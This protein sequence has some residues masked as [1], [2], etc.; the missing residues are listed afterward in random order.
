MR[1]RLT[2]KQWLITTGALIAG[3]LVVCCGISA[4]LPSEEPRRNAPI[5]TF[6]EASP[7]FAHPTS[8]PIIT[9]QAPAPPK[10][11][12]APL[13]TIDDGVWTVGV[14]VPAG[15]YR[16][17]ERIAGTCYW[18][19]YRSDTNQETIISNDL[20]SGG[21]PTVTIKRGQDFETS[22]CGTWEKV[23]KR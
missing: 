4:V 10:P 13:V 5:T 3:I 2:K 20:P 11:T 16:V 23:Q 1:R 12:A 19:I 22:G 7:T 17:V 6:T 8:K 15:K 18:A 14:D 9:T 21:R